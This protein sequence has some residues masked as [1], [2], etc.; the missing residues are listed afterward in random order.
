M[1]VREFLINCINSDCFKI[2]VLNLNGDEVSVEDAA[3]YTVG[4]FHISKALN[5]ITIC[6]EE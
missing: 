5:T 2:R 1:T 6:T 3:D 4:M